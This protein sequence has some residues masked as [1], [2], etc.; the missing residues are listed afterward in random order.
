MDREKEEGDLQRKLTL[1]NNFIS[2]HV[3]VSLYDG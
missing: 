2:D 3:W 1:V